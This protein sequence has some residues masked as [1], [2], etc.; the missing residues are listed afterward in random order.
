MLS[1]GLPVYGRLRGLRLV[2]SLLWIYHSGNTGENQVK[3]FI[4]LFCDARAVSTPFIAVRTFDPASTI[5][6]VRRSLG[7][8]DA[9]LTPLISWDSVHGLLGINEEGTKALSTMA[10]SAS[11]DVHASV[12]LPI[13]LG[14]LEFAQKDVIAF[15]HN[16]QLQWPTDVKVVQGTWNLRDIYKLNG[17]MLV[18]LIGAGDVLPIELQQDILV[19]D[20]PLPTREELA[21]I[22]KETFAFAAQEKKY[23]ACK[24]A[25]TEAVVKAACDALIGLPAFPAEQST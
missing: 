2:P 4:E 5:Q 12:D 15:L 7:K 14:I 18:L 13:A 24:N 16:P 25:A 6:N 19:I 10:T 23:I 17:N 22:I 8:E 11:I 20:E 1:A 3:T 21:V 9:E